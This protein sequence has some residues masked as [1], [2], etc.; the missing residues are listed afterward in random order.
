MTPDE[1]YEEES[2]YIT[3]QG[4]KYMLVGAYAKT[5]TKHFSNMPQY[6]DSTDIKN[7]IIAELAAQNQLSKSK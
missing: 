3:I 4:K 6:D 1:Y 2:Q 7:V 5:V